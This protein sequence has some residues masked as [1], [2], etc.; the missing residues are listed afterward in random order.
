[1]ASLLT[2]PLTLPHKKVNSGISGPS[3]TTTL[4]NRVF[5]PQLRTGGYLSQN[6][7]IKAKAKASLGS[8]VT[9]KDSTGVEE[10]DADESDFGVVSL[11]HVG[12]LCENLERSLNFYQNIL[13]LTI[14]EA[15]PHDKLPYRGAWLWAGS[16]MIHL[17]ELP[18]PDPVTGRPEY[19]GRDRHACI[20]IRDV[21]KLKA[22]LDKAGIPYNLSS[23]GRAAIFSRDPDGNG[24]EFIQV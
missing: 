18:N 19:G 3:A 23:S 2:P 20:L 12:I 22:I 6:T 5:L 16:V 9:A 11:H 15:R 21:T 1:M 13:G 8:E 24:L 7:D 4:S 10:V 17:M 14:N